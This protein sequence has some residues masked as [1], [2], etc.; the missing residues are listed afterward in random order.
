MP[1][2]VNLC[3]VFLPTV[4]DRKKGFHKATSL[5]VKQRALPRS[6]RLL[7][8]KMMNMEDFNRLIHKVVEESKPASSLAKS[9]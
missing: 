4:R 3:A 6:V 7:I 1:Q 8:Q 9:K 2:E 5:S